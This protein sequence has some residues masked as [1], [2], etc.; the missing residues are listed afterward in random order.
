MQE[1]TNSRTGLPA[2]VGASGHHDD[3]KKRRKRAHLRDAEALF[4]PTGGVAVV[5]DYKVPFRV[6]CRDHV[7]DLF[8]TSESLQGSCHRFGRNGIECLCPIEGQKD[9]FALLQRPRVLYHATCNEQCI[10]CA[11]ATPE[12]ELCVP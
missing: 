4:V 8:S 2:G 11:T 10:A 3:E 5:P 9:N 6:N 12:A 1:A 7:N